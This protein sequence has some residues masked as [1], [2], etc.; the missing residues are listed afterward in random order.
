MAESEERIFKPR[1]KHLLPVAL[2]LAATGILGYPIANSG[3]PAAQVTPFAGNDLPSAIP[4]ALI[5]VLALGASATVMLLMIRRGRMGFIRRMIKGALI[6]VSFAVTL[7]YTTSLLPLDFSFLLA[8][9]LGVAALIGVFLGYSIPLITALVLVGA[10]VVYDIVAVF[11]GP[12]GALAKTVGA[13]DLP[14]A[15][16]SYGELTIG[17]GDLVFYSLVATI[18]MLGFGLVSFFGAA[19]GILAGT[20]LGFRALSR[21]EM[22]PGLPFSLLLGVAGMLLPMAIAT[23][24]SLLHL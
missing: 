18:A 23:L 10:L 5:F 9:S 11:R 20:Y 2:G 1:P 6:I 17:M 12:V 19:I 15:M 22:F 4:D 8:L 3:A 7:W 14:G 13:G 16:Y 24:V 21:F